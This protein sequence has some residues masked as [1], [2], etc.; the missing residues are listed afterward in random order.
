[1]D[2]ERESRRARVP[3]RRLGFCARASGMLALT[4][5]I[6]GIMAAPA[7][8][9]GVA[10]SLRIR[11]D[12]GHPTSLLVMSNQPSEAPLQVIWF[13]GDRDPVT[14]R[15]P[16]GQT[17]ELCSCLRD[18]GA[19]KRA[20]PL[21]LILKKGSEGLKLEMAYDGASCWGGSGEPP[22]PSPTPRGSTG[23]KPVRSEPKRVEVRPLLILVHGS[24][25]YPEVAREMEAARTPKLKTM[26]IVADASRLSFTAAFT[27]PF[28]FQPGSRV[29]VSRL[30]RRAAKDDVLIGKVPLGNTGSTSAAFPI[31]DIVGTSVSWYIRTSL[32]RPDPPLKPGERLQVKFSLENLEFETEAVVTARQQ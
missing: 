1:M 4:L 27:I 29:V 31:R 19:E 32:L 7:G 10:G 15:S 26:E 22:A 23:P 6:S 25:V 8:A 9:E 24:E 14:Y 18:L 13:P 11:L 3:S 17:I 12:P 20:G 28:P 5:S 30:V 2:R 21:Q 16:D